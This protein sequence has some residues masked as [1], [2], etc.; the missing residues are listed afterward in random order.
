MPDVIKGIN[1]KNYHS[2]DIPLDR[3]VVEILS[4]I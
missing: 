3:S 2:S 4:K 1:G